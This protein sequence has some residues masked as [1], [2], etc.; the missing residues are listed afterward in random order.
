MGIGHALMSQIMTDLATLNVETVRTE[1]A[2][3]N[4]GLLD[5]LAKHGPP[6]FRLYL[7]DLDMLPRP[8]F[9]MFFFCSEI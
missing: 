1:I 4:F 9:A 2:W 7:R 8:G 3:N 5:F 6:G